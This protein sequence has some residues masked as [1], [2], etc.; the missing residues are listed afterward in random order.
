[1]STDESEKDEPKTER[2]NMFMSRSQM[3]AIDD[4]AWEKRIRSK[5]E[6]VRQLIETGLVY[7]RYAPSL[8]ELGHRL[9]RAAYNNEKLNDAMHAKV[10][11][12]SA[13]EIMSELVMTIVTMESIIEVMTVSRSD[14]R[15]E[16]IAARDKLIEELEYFGREAKDE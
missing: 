14:K 3:K 4:W 13:H 12:T 1:M 15:E 6:A 16:A 11:G 5:S 7:H 9:A 8:Q 10:D 2:F